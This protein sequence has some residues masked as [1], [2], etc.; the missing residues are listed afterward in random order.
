MLPRKKPGNPR[1]IASRSRLARR[2]VEEE[3]GVAL[4]CERFCIGG[5]DEQV[6]V[7]ADAYGVGDL[8]SSRDAGPGATTH[9]RCA[10]WNLESRHAVAW[11]E[12]DVASVHRS[13]HGDL[14]VL[15][16]VT[17]PGN[18]PPPRG[19]IHVV[20]TFSTRNCPQR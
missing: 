6:G 9:V 14:S 18:E 4:Q 3:H 7:R 10:H 2:R 1:G 20:Y 12:R 5:R 11:Y 19:V 17:E 13:I 16:S 15:E 8:W